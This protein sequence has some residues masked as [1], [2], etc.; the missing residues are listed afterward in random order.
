MHW[1]IVKIFVITSVNLHFLSVF[2]RTVH[3]GLPLLVRHDED[4]ETLHKFHRGLDFSSLTNDL[5]KFD[6]KQ[7]EDIKY[8]R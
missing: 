8:Y 4:E 1:I 5:V 7:G 6:L 2:G 3:L